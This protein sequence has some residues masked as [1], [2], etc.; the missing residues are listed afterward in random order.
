MQP[1]NIH[2]VRAKKA[3]IAHVF[4]N[5]FLKIGLRIVLWVTLLSGLAAVVV[6]ENWGFLLLA[7]ASASL[8]LILW[9]KG[10]L[11]KL[12]KTHG[13]SSIDGLLD[14]EVLANLRVNDPSAMEVWQAAK[15]TEASYFFQSRFIL[16][17]S[18]FDQFLSKEPNSANLIW[19]RAESLR[20]KYSLPDYH[21]NVI[22]VALLKSIPNIEQLLAQ[23]KL[24]MTDIESGIAWFNSILAKRE[25][26]SKRQHFGGLGRDLAY[27]YTP[28]LGSLGHNI[29]REVE[30]YGFFEDTSVHD[31]IVDQMVNAMGSGN[32]E[33]ALV[34]EVGSGRTTS[35]YGFAKRL[36]VPGDVPPSIRHHQVVGLDAPALIS[37]ARNPGEL[38]NLMIQLL[39]E[40]I[41]A[42]NII[43][44]FDDAHVFFSE[45]TG[46]VDLSKVL[47]PVLES[48]SVRMIFALTPKELQQLGSSTSIVSRLQRMQV[49]PSDEA[50]TIHVLRDRVLIY[51]HQHK[52]LFTNQAL[53]EAFRLGSR[54]VDDQVMPGAALSVLK[55][56]APLAKDGYV[57]AEVVQRSVETSQGVK[58]TSAQQDESA[59]LLDLEDDLHKYVINQKQAVSVI[60]DALR[61][62]RS[63]V[64]NPD[65]P[66]GTFLFL[67]PTGVGK[68]ELS[69]ALARVYFGSEEAIVRVDMNQFVRPEDVDRLITP[70]L[71]KQL[72]F[73]GQMRARPF[74]VVLL[75]EIEKAHPSVVN[76]LLQMLDEG[77]MK[78]IDNKA[79]SFKD[80]IVI[81]TSNAGADKIRQMIQDGE[82]IIA[83]QEKLTDYIIEQKIFAPEFVNRFDEV[84]MFRP[85]TPDELLSVIGL[86]I[87]SINQTLDKQKV[88]VE[89]TESAKKW[90]VE[91][92]Y[93]QR[94]GARPMRRMAQKYVENILAKKLLEKSAGSGSLVNLDVADFENLD[95]ND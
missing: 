86:I 82:D 54:Y 45:G 47:L 73:L 65:R 1:I 35:V 74:S 69:K 44:F 55:A 76:L 57:T 8:M 10:E 90:L 95:H 38:E 36:L 78:D 88:Q 91:K 33:L 39:N 3:R 14:P 7:M 79:V 21:A 83:A 15:N 25:L 48:G 81:A 40:A 93:D 6:D 42:K 50:S 89:L 53:R 46:S 92:G 94:L 84:V 61:R 31:Q 59:K 64:G 77:E 4:R 67:G 71:G 43:L 68:T 18:I 37:H 56:A 5:N 20:K 9:N 32:S 85:L 62:S 26:A 72:S 12:H 11:Q 30:Q 60:A 19:E 22:I 16:H 24:E 13:H 51:E 70:L 17:P 58:L 80:A 75:D 28:I 23:A 52:V 41:R 63:G 66:V 29:S 87:A 34:G 27:G 49:Q 2:S